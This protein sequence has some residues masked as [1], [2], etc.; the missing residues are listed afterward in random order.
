[1]RKKSHISLACYLV[2]Q[3]NFQE[4]INHKKAFYVGSILP[5]CKPS[6]LT[7]KHE[8]G[9]TFSMVQERIVSLTAD[10]D[11]LTNRSGRFMRE[12]GEIIHYM[13]DYF[14][15]PH[16]ITYDGNLEDHCYYEKDLK[17]GLRAYIKS[18]QAVQEKQEYLPIQSADE[19]FAYIGASHKEYLSR[20]RNVEQ[21]CQYIV[22]VCCQVLHTIVFLIQ[23]ALAL[24]TS[25]NNPISKAY[26]TA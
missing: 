20:K 26:V 5:D 2:S 23:R 14:T 18:G 17:F 13:A 11:G 6:F 25:Q 9:E 19:L 8:F 7:T 15:F 1:M 3:T 10:V 22:H 24:A 12:M 16:N 21:D 4:L